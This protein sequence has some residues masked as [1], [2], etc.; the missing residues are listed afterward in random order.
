[1]SLESNRADFE[2]ALEEMK[3]TMELLDNCVDDALM[4][5]LRDVVNEY[6]H[7]V[8]DID[9]VIDSVSQLEDELTNA[10]TNQIELQSTIDE[11]ESELTV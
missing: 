11:L 2:K 5:T 8:N 3:N 10:E 4:E 1:M 9:E 7:Y 6:E